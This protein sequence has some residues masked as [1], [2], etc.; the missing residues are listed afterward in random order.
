MYKRQ[1][2][3]IAAASPEQTDA[4]LAEAAAEYQ[5]E[6]A[7]QL[8]ENTALDIAMFGIDVY[9]RQQAVGG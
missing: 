7:A 4:V 5:R 1:A 9:K 2:E 3:E 8:G 6:L